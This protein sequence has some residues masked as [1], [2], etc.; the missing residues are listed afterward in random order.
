[1]RFARRSR[2]ISATQTLLA[3][4]LVSLCVSRTSAQESSYHLVPT[5]KGWGE[6]VAHAPLALATS[7]NRI[8]WHG[9]PVMHGNVHVYFIWY[10]NWLNGAHPFDSDYTT[11]LLKTLFAATDGIGNSSYARINTTYGDTTGPVTA[12]M[13]WTRSAADKYSQGTSLS[14]AAVRR[15]VYNAI[16]SRK[17]PK[18][19]NG[20]YFVLTSSDVA[21]TSGFCTSYCGW[22][23][24]DIILG[25]DIKYA[26][27]GN[28]DRCPDACEVQ[29]ISPNHNSGAD[30]M[31]SIMAHEAEE[32]LTDPDL[33]AWYDSLGNENADKCAWTFGPTV[34]QI[35]RGAYNQIFGTHRWLIQMNWEN[36]RG[37][38][39]AQRLSGAFYTR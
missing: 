21:E 3:L 4:L 20:I 5:G 13:A 6:A 8:S 34:G 15:V 39:C 22:H 1:M 27:V 17:L 37:G 25:A 16:N 12:N 10:G 32:I 30:G 14:D 31:A 23:T 18:D 28:L 29:D 26:F 24:S 2:G 9:G 38:G 7:G 36:T 35:G 33:N 19:E 11:Y